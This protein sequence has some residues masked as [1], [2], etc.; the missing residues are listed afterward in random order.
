MPI[1][2]TFRR[3]YRRA[4]QDASNLAFQRKIVCE[5]ASA[6]YAASKP[7]DPYWQNSERC[8]AREAQY[9]WEEILKLKPRQD[10]DESHS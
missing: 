7:D 9:I 6:K 10:R 4:L 2:E 8:A 3:G 1:S 5:D